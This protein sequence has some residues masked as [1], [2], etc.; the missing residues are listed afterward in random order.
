MKGNNKMEQLKVKFPAYTPDYVIDE[1]EY[2]YEKI[3]NGKS[4]VF[5]LDNAIM[6]VNLA[7]VSSRISKE[8]G[9]IIKKIIRNM[10]KNDR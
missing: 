3:S 9:K 10:Q 2:Y 6:L 7:V 5:T 1:V 8:Q 4:D